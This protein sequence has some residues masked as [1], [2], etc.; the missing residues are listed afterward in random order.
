MEFW[1]TIVGLLRRPKVIVPVVLAALTLGALAFMGT[2]VT[3]VSSTTMV[4]T[5]TQ[6]G[7]SESLNPTEPTPL[8][9]PMLNF[10]SSL[11]TTSGILIQSISTREALTELGARG[12]STR[13]IVNDGRTN[14]GLLGLDGP[15]LYVEGRSVSRDDARRV[16][17]DAQEMLRKRLSEWQRDL[18]AP[19]K[20]YVS[21]VDV[22]SPTAPEVDAGRPI[23]LG[24]V[25]FL[26]GFLLALGIAYFRHVTRARR[27]ARVTAAAPAGPR[28]TVARPKVRRPTFPRPV[29]PADL[30]R[31]ARVGVP[32]VSERELEP[33]I[34]ATPL[35]RSPEPVAV[36][37]MAGRDAPADP[38]AGRP[39]AEP[40]LPHVPLKVNGRSRR[41]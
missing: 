27:R 25:A 18:N 31:G 19:E 32:L 7:G 10:N 9:N 39:G 4:L 23:R 14:P 16:V 41:R 11:Q 33:T 26:L 15:F 6:Y 13:L 30:D 34:V 28:P 21:L 17:V 20:T 37:A 35:R 12:G 38:V 29:G 22:V 3:Y 1:S 5:T 40:G 24:A 2:P 36:A 8:T